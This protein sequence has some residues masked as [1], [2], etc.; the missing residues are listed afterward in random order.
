MREIVLLI[1]DGG[2]RFLPRTVACLW[3]FDMS[4]RK[5]R[6]AAEDRSGSS[7]MSQEYLFSVV[8]CTFLRGAVAIGIDIIIIAAVVDVDKRSLRDTTQVRQGR[9]D[10]GFVAAAHLKLAKPES[11]LS[12]G[13]LVEW[14]VKC[15]VPRVK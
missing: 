11:S 6:V 5:Q 15:H 1:R 9:P 3:W 2:A 4:T 10:L 8:S 14:G 13:P 12:F 7:D